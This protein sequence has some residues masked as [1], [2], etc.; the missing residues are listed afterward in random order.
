MIEPTESETKEEMDRYCDALISIRKEIE[1]VIEGKY[2]QEDNVVVNA[3]HTCKYIT[4]TKWDH[5]YSREKAAWKVDVE[6]WE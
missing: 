1:E 6:P 4:S 5:T 2:T 3:P